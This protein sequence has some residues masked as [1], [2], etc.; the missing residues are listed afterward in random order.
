MKF[1]LALDIQEK[2]KLIRI[3]E[4]THP[5]V[6]LFKVGPIALFS[7]GLEVFKYISRVKKDVFLDMKFFD[8]PSVVS[9]TI[10]SLGDV[11][12][13]ILTVHAS[14]GRDILKSAVLSARELDIEV[15]AV[16]KLT[17]DDADLESVLELSEIAENCGA[18]WVVCQPQF[19]KDIKAKTKLKVI[20]PGIRISENTD[21][22]KNTLTPYEAKLAGIDMI[23]IGRPII[24]SDNPYGQ[25]KKV[26]EMI[27][28][29]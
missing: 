3:I 28:L 9:R 26:R 12:V 18:T 24:L 2:D 20:S 11:G 5:F 7:F 6:D 21:E 10:S 27:D 17:S 29:A 16:T 13:K 8:I 1:A 14:G 15:A 4:E 22:H 23:V 19:S 25:A